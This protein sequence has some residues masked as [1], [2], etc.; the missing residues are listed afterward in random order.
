MGALREIRRYW[1]GQICADLKIN[2]GA[3]GEVLMAKDAGATSVTA[4]GNSSKET[5]QIFVD[6]CKK[7]GI[8][9]VIDMMNNQNPLKTLWKSNVVPAVVFIHRG[10]DEENAFGK[11]LQYKDVAKI[12]GKWDIEVGVAGGIDER[13][14]QS[15]IFNSADIVVVNIVQPGSPWKG[16]VFDENFNTSLQR[17]LR[18]VE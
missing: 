7:L 12:K 10:R 8:I 17:F 16:I 15:A 13:E 1:R 5:L 6:S 18:F 11:I 9:S 4:M 3:Y 2:D 14:L